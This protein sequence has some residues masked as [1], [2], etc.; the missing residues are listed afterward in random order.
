MQAIAAENNLSET[1]F[2]VPSE[3]DDADLRPALVHAGR[4]K[5]T[6]AA[7]RRSPPGHI[8]MTGATG[9]LLDRVG[10]R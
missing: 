9:P 5:S 4:A 7:M 1:A 3:R 6:C 10:R 8:L 2:T